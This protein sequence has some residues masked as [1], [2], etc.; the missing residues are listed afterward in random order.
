MLDSG[1]EGKA[2]KKPRL[3]K[4]IVGKRLEWDWSNPFSGI[5]GLLYLGAR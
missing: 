1:T 2:V 5:S 3:Q 4:S